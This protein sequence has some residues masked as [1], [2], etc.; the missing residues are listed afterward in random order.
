MDKSVFLSLIFDIIAPRFVEEEMAVN[1]LVSDDGDEVL[2]IDFYPYKLVKPPLKFDGVLNV[3]Y[4][5]LFGFALFT[6]PI[7]ELRP[8]SYP[9]LS[10]AL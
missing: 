7:S 8:F 9:A 1:V 2:V 10:D 3:R 5:N 6:K 4:F